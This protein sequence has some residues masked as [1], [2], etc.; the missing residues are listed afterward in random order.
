MIIPIFEE[1]SEIG[2][3]L[4]T[5]EANH[6]T[7]EKAKKGVKH[8]FRLLKS[9]ERDKIKTEPLKKKTDE[10]LKLK[11]DSI[12]VRRSVFVD[13]TKSLSTFQS[14]VQY[15]APDYVSGSV[16]VCER[17]A[18]DGFSG[19][20]LVQ[21]CGTVSPKIVV[22]PEETKTSNIKQVEIAVADPLDPKNE[23]KKKVAEPKSSI[24]LQKA[25]LNSR[26]NSIYTRMSKAAKSTQSS[27]CLVFQVNEKGGPTVR[28]LEFGDAFENERMTLSTDEN[29]FKISPIVLAKVVKAEAL[30]KS[31]LKSPNEKKKAKPKETHKDLFVTVKPRTYLFTNPET[32][33]VHSTDVNNPNTTQYNP[34]SSPVTQVDYNANIPITLPKG[35]SMTR[36][37]A[38]TPPATIVSVQATCA[39][40]SVTQNVSRLTQSSHNAP[41]PTDISVSGISKDVATVS[42]PSPIVAKKSRVVSSLLSVSQ[43]I[44]PVNATVSMT[45]VNTTKCKVSPVNVI[46]RRLSPVTS[47]AGLI[48]SPRTSSESSS[49]KTATTT[50]VS[51]VT[52]MSLSLPTVHAGMASVPG[53][54]TSVTTATEISSLGSAP[55]DTSISRGTPPP[56]VSAWIQPS[57]TTTTRLTQEV[58]MYERLSAVSSPVSF[59]GMS[60]G[61]TAVT[62]K[63]GGS[64]EVLRMSEQSMHTVSNFEVEPALSEQEDIVDTFDHALPAV[65][66]EN[67]LQGFRTEDNDISAAETPQD[68]VCTVPDTKSNF[69]IFQSDSEEELKTPEKIDLKSDSKSKLVPKKLV[70]S[71]KR[72]LVTPEAGSAKS[73]VSKISQKYDNKRTPR[74]RNSSGVNAGRRKVV[75]FGTGVSHKIR[76][77]LKSKVETFEPFINDEEEEEELPNEDME[78][79]KMPKPMRTSKGITDEDIEKML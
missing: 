14:E 71:A 23:N 66:S 21:R 50:V 25:K 9:A 32:E 2:D 12:Q 19:K 52:T 36:L 35:L 62:T 48:P 28:Y 26:L 43:A 61:T 8:D 11:R 55:A 38:S 1:E 57:V 64:S 3:K 63:S 67:N 75:L 45:A 56:P 34:T 30:E 51:G 5:A 15:F 47:V 16:L 31:F 72:K 33:Q 27:F 10:D 74:T 22:L 41:K 49:A 60:G 59:T 37:S 44:T 58:T 53:H 68:L 79:K 65:L 69:S 18:E 6:N 29:R 46:C 78:T 70:V 40:P 4:E 13:R 17:P 77:P 7:P 73:K 76:K 54:T 39:R 24:P 20:F 42:E